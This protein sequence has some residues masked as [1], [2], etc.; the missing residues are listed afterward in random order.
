MAL[1]VEQ[2]PHL[3]IRIL[4]MR[5][6]KISKQSKTRYS[7][8]L[9]KRNIKY[10]ISEYGIIPEEWLAEKKDNKDAN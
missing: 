8:W 6:N 1:V 7:D 4:L 9:E 2:N 5:D 10:A 3:D